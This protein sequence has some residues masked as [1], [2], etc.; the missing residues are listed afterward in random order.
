MNTEESISTTPAVDRAKITG[1]TVACVY[2]DDFAAAHTFYADL[3]GLELQYDM[4][5][6]A[7]YFKINE[8][9][10]LYLEGGNVR[11]Q[12]VDP[13]S[14]RASFIMY[15]GSASAM[16]QKLRDAGVRTVQSELTNMGGDDYWFQFYDP[17]G[18]II[19]ILGGL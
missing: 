4:G 9:C 14:V 5:A 3:L 13:K 17:A 1:L 12:E 15:V 8:T 7:G 10:G 19:E 16:F 11:R 6:N 18:N 2:V